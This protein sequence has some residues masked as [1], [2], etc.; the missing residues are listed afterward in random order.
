MA[1][2]G[3]LETP[4]PLKAISLF[5]KQVRLLAGTP[6]EEKRNCTVFSSAVK[7]SKLIDQLFALN[8]QG[9]NTLGRLSN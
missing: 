3:V 5:S 4:P 6:S 7:K 2:D 8:V 1:E 9:L